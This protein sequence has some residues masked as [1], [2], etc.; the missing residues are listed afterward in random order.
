M[1]K[2]ALI[3]FLKEKRT[4]AEIVDQIKGDKEEVLN[5]LR[6]LKHEGRLERFVEDEKKYYR[7]TGK[8]K[9]EKKKSTI[10]SNIRHLQLWP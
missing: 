3:E 8:K 1:E 9:P 4:V 7:I 10:Y 2:E 6:E 5:A